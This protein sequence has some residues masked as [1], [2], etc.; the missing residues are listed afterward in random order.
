MLSGC[1]LGAEKRFDHP[2]AGSGVDGSGPWGDGGAYDIKAVIRFSHAKLLLSPTLAAC[3]D[4]TV[5]FDSRAGIGSED[6]LVFLT[7][8]GGDPDAVVTALAADPTVADFLL[9]AEFDTES[10]F[11]IRPDADAYRF[12][13]LFS[14]LGAVVRDIHS[15]DGGWIVDAYL[16]NRGVLATLVEYG[17]QSDVTIR[18]KQLADLRRIRDPGAPLLTSGQRDLLLTANEHG[19]FETPRR[20]SQRELAAMF[21]VSPS[22]ISQRLRR[23]TGLLAADLSD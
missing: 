10:L 9:V 11:R 19:Y 21:D 23:V 16:P 14:E 2:E 3:P 1:S 15:S 5:R 8:I 4:T 18:V 17:E 6:D 7:A 13:P 12:R 20:I 22:A